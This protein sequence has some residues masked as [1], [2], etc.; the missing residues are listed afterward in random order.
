MHYLDTIAAEI[1]RRSEGTPIHDSDLGLYRIYA[2]LALAKG[3]ETTNEDVHNA[4]AAWTAAAAPAHR[5]LVPYDRLPP[6]VQALDTPYTLA[7]RQVAAWW[8]SG[9][10]P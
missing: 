2:V 8:S 5:S 7:I 4:W 9:A 6:Q 3:L 10:R 1:Q